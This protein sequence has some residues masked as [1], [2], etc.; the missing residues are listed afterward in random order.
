MVSQS[1]KLP[2]RIENSTRDSRFLNERGA[3]MPRSFSS[4]PRRGFTLIELLVVIAIIGLLIGLLLPAVLAARQAANRLYCV[5]NLKNLGLALHN[6]HGDWNTFPPGAVGPVGGLPQYDAW[7]Q[8]GLGTYLLPFLEQKALAD[9]YRWDVSWFDPPNQTVVNT[10]LA[11]FQCPSAQPNRIADESLPTVTP[12]RSEPFNGT[13]ACSDYAGSSIVDAGLVA[14]GVLDSIGGPRDQKGNLEGVFPANH[15]TCLAGI[16]DGSSNTIM[17]AECAGRPQLWHA[18]S[19]VPNKQL[20]GSAWAS[21]NVLWCRGA[22][23]N[24]SAFYASCAINCTNDREVYSFHPNG[25]NILFADA[26][27]QLV[28][29]T[30][31]IRVY[32][33]LVTRAGGEI[34]SADDY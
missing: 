24:G 16:T 33:R 7:K 10:Q 26:R 4:A 32:A 11:V 6:Y 1:L 5:N 12:P 8:H 13:A 20:S 15:A 18:S 30:I 31:D 2:E 27:V 28:K 17:M 21:R 9:A 22:T 23:L 29:S 25:A 19:P 3:A 14:A 34:I